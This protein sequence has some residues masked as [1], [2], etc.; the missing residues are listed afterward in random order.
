VAK[1]EVPV[2][3]SAVFSAACS[4]VL[5]LYCFVN[6]RLKPSDLFRPRYFSEDTQGH[7]E[8][9]TTPFLGTY[10]KFRACSRICTLCAFSHTDTQSGYRVSSYSIYLDKQTGYCVSCLYNCRHS[11]TLLYMEGKKDHECGC[12]KVLVYSYHISVYCSLD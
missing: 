8:L 1:R 2:L 6:T 4:Q 5:V 11:S 9:V 7:L 10:N 3:S 12:E